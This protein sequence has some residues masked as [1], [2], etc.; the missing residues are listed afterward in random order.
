MS[1]IVVIGVGNAFRGDDGAG[2]AAAERLAGLLPRDITVVPCELEPSRLIDAWEGA[3]AALIVDAVSSGAEPGTVRRF[4]AGTEPLPAR[5]F[6][7]STHA[8]GVGE[9]IE[10]ARALG[11]LPEHV[12]VYGIEGAVFASGEGLTAPVATAVGAVVEAVV[13]DVERLGREEEPCTSER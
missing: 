7:S 11:T 10:L 2:L 8:F 3:S 4:D 9:A 13:A 6:R 12:V 1:G 5:V